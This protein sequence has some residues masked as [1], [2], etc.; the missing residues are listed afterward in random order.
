M[1]LTLALSVL[2]GSLSK[3][4]VRQKITWSSNTRGACSDAGNNKNVENIF[5]K[6]KELFI[7][8]PNKSQMMP[9][10][11]FKKHPSR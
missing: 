2:A 4:T 8:K 9:Y 1:S 6:N 3:E 5:I 7:G 10:W 11:Q